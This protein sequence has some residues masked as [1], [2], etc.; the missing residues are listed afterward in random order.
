MA[1]AEKYEQTRIYTW[2]SLGIIVYGNF[3]TVFM[4]LFMFGRKG[5]LGPKRQ[6]LFTRG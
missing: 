1:Y 3:N 2:K 6:S 4:N 5:Y